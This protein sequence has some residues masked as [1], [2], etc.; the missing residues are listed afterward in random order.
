[1]YPEWTGLKW[2]DVER[3]F[4]DQLQG[5]LE[6]ATSLDDVSESVDD[7]LGRVRSCVDDAIAHGHE[8]IVVVGHQDPS[9]ILRLGLVGRPLSELRV[10]P[11][12]HASA[13][14]ITYVGDGRFVEDSVWS[15]QDIDL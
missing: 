8:T 4:P 13:T 3:K 12:E 11:P 14:T 5:Y 10:D 1:M 7:V 6:D 9:Q 15:P 2:D